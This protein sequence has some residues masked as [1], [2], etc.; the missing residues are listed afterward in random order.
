[1]SRFKVHRHTGGLENATVGIDGDKWVHRHT[2]GLEKK[3]HGRGGAS[4]VHRH[5]GG[6]ENVVVF[7]RPIV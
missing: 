7:I 5:T 6:L 2:G 1:M 4:I 3:Q